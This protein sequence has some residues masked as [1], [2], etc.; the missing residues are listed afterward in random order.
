MP[1]E[2]CISWIVA[3]RMGLR[4]GQRSA[5]DQTECE[6]PVAVTQAAHQAEQLGILK[7]L[8]SLAEH[9]CSAE[10]HDGGLDDALQTHVEKYSR[11]FGLF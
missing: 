10:V 4:A 3:W 2:S 6:Q 5:V 7:G 1:V 9:R 11:F 8:G